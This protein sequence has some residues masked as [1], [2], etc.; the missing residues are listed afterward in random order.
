MRFKTLSGL[1]LL[2]SLQAGCGSSGSD[3]GN[4]PPIAYPVTQRGDV[5]DHYFGKAIA[6]PYRWLENNPAEDSDVA[7][8]IEAQKRT[9]S[10][11][12][13]ALPGRD[14]FRKTLAS[15]YNY[16]RIGAPQKEGDRYFYTRKGGQQKQPSLYV[17]EGAN[18]GDRV[19]V[20]PAEWSDDGSIAIQEWR[21]SK[22]GAHLAYAVQDGGSDWRTI[23]VLDVA[24]GQT[25][26]DELKWA[27]L[28][29]IAWAKDGSGFF[30][31][32]YPEPTGGIDDGSGLVN[33][34]V[35]FHRVG[36]PQAQDELF[37][38]TPEQPYLANPVGMT[39]DGRYVVVYTTADLV[40]T[41]VTL[42]DLESGDRLPRKLIETPEHSWSIIG[43]VGTKLFL[44]TNKDAV[45]SKIVTVDLAAP[46][47]VFTDLV[48][49][50]DAILKA[51]Y[52]VGDRL[53]V[54]YMVDAKSEMRRFTLDG[55]P[56]GGVDLPLIGS[57]TALTGDAQDP[58]AFFV[59]ASFNEPNTV[60]RYD[61]STNTQEVWVEPQIEADLEQ[62]VAEQVFYESKDGTRIPM[63]IVRRKDVSGPT[64][65]MLTSYGAFATSMPPAYSAML[66]GWL[67]QGGVVALPGIRGGGEYGAPWHAA[68]TREQKQNTF[69][70]FI[71]AAEYLH[72]NEIAP[73]DGIAIYGD[74][75]G[76]LLIGA[77][78]NQRPDLFGAALP[79]VG[80]MDMLRYNRFTGGQLWVGEYGDPAVEADF[81]NLLSYSPYHNIR[82]GNSYPAILATTGEADTRVVPAH[83]F[84][85]V[86]ELQAADLG[87]KPRL[88]RIDARAGHGAGKPTTQV[89]EEAADMWAFAARWT[90]L[91]VQDAR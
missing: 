35:Y 65:T 11:C 41:A 14:A 23:K 5:V 12:L 10:A 32:R 53:L 18:G 26:D 71:A 16:E 85:Y 6:D 44:T 43:N 87:P 70:D 45:R 29:Q 50:Q 47:P 82:T 20:D 86:A 64:P 49:Q 81:N 55:A 38:S 78:V 68:G 62:I 24:T 90:G 36:T 67:L 25:L 30:Y 83:S 76:G 39:S 58:E 28:T 37:Y 4:A 48:P 88:L 46:E 79:S 72:A 51:A 27:R 13:E 80:V 75:A 21:A 3:H 77:V 66:T 17:R 61:V 54:S 91:E 59:F 7:A 15:T 31:S 19:L 2:A 69:D 56:D 34:A 1:I 73:A 60:F 22:D 63:F 9:S 52:L 74:S 33:H 42:V 40:H 8:W 89:I 57:V 84:K